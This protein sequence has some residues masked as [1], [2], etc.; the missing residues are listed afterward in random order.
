MKGLFIVTV[1][2]AGLCATFLEGCGSSHITSLGASAAF[3][4]GNIVITNN[5]TSSWTNVVLLLNDSFLYR[6]EQVN[7]Q[8]T[9][10]IPA[11]EFI[12]NGK[13]F[14]ASDTKPWIIK[15]SCS[16]EN[17]KHGEFVG[18]WH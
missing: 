10:T 16:L 8:Q 6:L 15:I 13:S 17:G 18:S 14:E 7:P 9:V 11:N 2:L 12:Y 4:E 5:T 3:I 1:V